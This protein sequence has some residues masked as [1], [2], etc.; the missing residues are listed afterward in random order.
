MSQ[1]TE[2]VERVSQASR[3][4][5]RTDGLTESDSPQG[6][7]L[8]SRFTRG[9]ALNLHAI[10]DATWV[11]HCFCAS[12]AKLYVGI[13]KDL[14]R[15]LTQHRAAQPWWPHVDSVVADLYPTRRQALDVEAFYIKQGGRLKNVQGAPPEIAAPHRWIMRRDVTCRGGVIHPHEYSVLPNGAITW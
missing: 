13:A 5:G 8:A 1:S 14:I 12:G 6:D 4:D 9:G 10:N 2:S 15:R 11:Y 7:Q 3:T